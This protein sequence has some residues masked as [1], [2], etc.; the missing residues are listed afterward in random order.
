MLLV[1]LLMYLFVREGV[2]KGIFVLKGGYYDFV[3]GV[4][5]FWEF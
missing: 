1:N 3:K 4:F 5:E 2:V